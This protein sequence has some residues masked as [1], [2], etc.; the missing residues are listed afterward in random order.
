[1]RAGPH[2]K[3]Y[4]HIKQSICES[5]LHPKGRFAISNNVLLRVVTGAICVD[6]KGHFRHIKTLQNTHSKTLLQ[7]GNGGGGGIL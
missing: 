4:T 7:A 3:V 5:C 2:Y 1:M 6:N